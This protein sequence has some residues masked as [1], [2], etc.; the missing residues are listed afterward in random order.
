MHSPTIG[1]NLI[2]TAFRAEIFDTVARRTRIALRLCVPAEPSVTCI[3]TRSGVLVAKRDEATEPKIWTSRATVDCDGATCDGLTVRIMRAARLHG[4]RIGD[5]LAA[6]ALDRPYAWSMT[7]TS[8]QGKEPGQA[9][10]QIEVIAMALR[11]PRAD[12]A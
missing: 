6:L 12:E 5:G 9:C 10:W 7:I 11:S 8:A 1:S 2:D 4:D 3:R